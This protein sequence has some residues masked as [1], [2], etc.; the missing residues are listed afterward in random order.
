ML[1]DL[2]LMEDEN[3]KKLLEVKRA[4]MQGKD[5]ILL[6]DVDDFVAG[7]QK[8]AQVMNLDKE[9]DAIEEESKDDGSVKLGSD[10]LAISDLAFKEFRERK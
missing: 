10:M 8:D 2:K 1:F 3:E 9:L 4:E 7:S 6:E 5:K